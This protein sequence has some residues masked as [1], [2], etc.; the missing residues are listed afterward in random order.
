MIAAA[1]RRADLDQLHAEHLAHEE[2][3]HLPRH[4]QVLRSRFGAESFRGDAPLLGHGIL[5]RVARQPSGSGRRERTQLVPQ[6]IARQLDGDFLVLE[7]RIR[8]EFD[9]GSLELADARPDILGDETDHFFRKRHLEMVDGGFLTQD[10]DTM[11]EIRRLDVRHHSPLE[12]AHE[13]RLEAGDF[14]GRPIARQHDLSA[15]LVEGVE[16]MEELFLCRL[17]TLEEMD[18]V[19]EEQVGF[20]EAPTK[21]A[22]RAIL[23]RGDQFVGELFRAQIGDPAARLVAD[24][25]VRDGLHEVRLAEPGVPIYE[26]RV[27]N[28]PG[29]LSHCMRS[30]CSEL[31]GLSDHKLFKNVA[32]A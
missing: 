17:L 31:V 5:D 10:R 4:C 13:T 23:N 29:S 30:R 26:K 16:G 21:F 18:V 32:L 14:R 3:G 19:D 28:L 15:R 9:D 20:A 2:H 11:L 6:R 27:I 25:L 24:D 1:E 12:P 22:R 7:R 8:Q